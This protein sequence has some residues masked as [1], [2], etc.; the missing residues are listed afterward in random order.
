V[1]VGIVVTVVP[2]QIQVLALVVLAGAAGGAVVGS[3][4]PDHI[5]PLA[6]VVAAVL[7]FTA[8]V[9]T[10]GVGLQLVERLD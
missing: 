3:S 2:V 7:G 5:L 4:L 8:K 6:V 9:Q 1:L 10:V